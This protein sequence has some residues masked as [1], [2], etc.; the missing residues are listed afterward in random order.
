MIIKRFFKVNS[1]EIEI[2]KV[3]F[4]LYE[5]FRVFVTL[6]KNLHTLLQS[7]SWVKKSFN[8]GSS[9]KLP[10]HRLRLRNTVLV[11]MVGTLLGHF[12]KSNN[13]EVFRVVSVQLHQAVLVTVRK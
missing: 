8:S 5:K 4:K 7:R 11:H 6:Y 9:K 12:F 10:L 3:N 13:A 2:Y 1:N